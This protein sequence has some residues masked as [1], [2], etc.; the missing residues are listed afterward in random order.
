N[1][2]TAA[3]VRDCGSATSCGGRVRSS[4]TARA[5]KSVVDS[6]ASSR[7]L[8]RVCK[9]AAPEFGEEEGTSQSWGD[10]CYADGAVILLGAR[11]TAGGVPD[12]ESRR[13]GGGLLQSWEGA[14]SAPRD[15]PLPTFETVVSPCRSR[16]V[17]SGEDGISA[18]RTSGI[19]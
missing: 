12:Q 8:A 19:A 2:I 3:W 9:H 5:P 11:R 14:V 7:S 18:R 6:S 15:G 10:T 16:G 13:R 4:S 1:P 17:G